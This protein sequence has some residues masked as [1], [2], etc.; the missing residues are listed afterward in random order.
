MNNQETSQKTGGTQHPGEFKIHFHMEGGIHRMSAIHRHKAE[1]ELLALLK[2]VSTVLGFHLDVETQAYGEGGVVEYFNLVVEN[3]EQ[4]AWVVS[5]LGPLLG[6]PFYLE[7]VKQTKQQTMLNDLNIQKAKIEIKEKEKAAAIDDQRPVQNV[8]LPLE[9]PPTHDAVAQALLARKKIARR[10]SNY[11][12]ALLN[13]SKIQ[14][15]G[16][17]SSHEKNAEERVVA[18]DQ[19]GDFV[20]AESAI[21]PLTYTHIPLEIVSPVLRS[22]TIKWRGI[23]EKKIVSF[24]LQ[25]ESFRELVSNKRVQFQNGTTLICD[26]EVL[27]REDDTGEIEISGYAVTKVYEVRNPEGG[28]TKRAEEQLRLG[29]PD[30][31][32]PAGQ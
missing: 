2:E 29:L 20:I 11:Y 8:P 30:D 10:R 7:K 31:D 25:D 12:A 21:D 32:N 13:D 22:G 9:S 19:F 15:I 6:V 23:F 16:F 18:R 24:E 5:L 3:K 1:G 28:P 26:F 4:I 27:Q 14:A 17:S